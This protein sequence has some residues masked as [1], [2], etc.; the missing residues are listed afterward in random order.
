MRS[1]LIG[2]N[3][4]RPFALQQRK[5]GDVVKDVAEI[6]EQDLARRGF[7]HVGKRGVQRGVGRSIG[8]L[9]IAPR[10]QQVEQRAG[11]STP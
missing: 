4:S 9:Q 2:S 11:F 3:S 7:G 10:S 1:T 6:A 8:R 5:G